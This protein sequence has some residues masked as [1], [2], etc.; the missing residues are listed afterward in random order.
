MHICY[1]ASYDSPYG[2]SARTLVFSRELV[3]LGHQVTIITSSYNH[4]MSK[5][6][7]PLNG[8]L[9]KDEIIDGVRIISVY[10]FNY[11]A[12]DQTI[13]RLIHM[14]QYSFLALIMAVVKL[15]RVDV[16]LGTT[17]PLFSGLLAWLLSKI[18]RSRFYIEIRDVWPEELIDLGSIKRG[19]LIAKIL[20]S[21]EKFL[22]K[23]SIKIISALPNTKEHVYKSGSN[24]EII[25]L[26]NPHDSDLQHQEYSGGK[27]NEL[28]IMY[29]GGSGRA[30]RINTLIEAFME[31]DLD[32][33]NLNIIGPVDFVENYFNKSNRKRPHNIKTQGFVDRS[34]LPVLFRNIDILVHPGNN[35]DQLK[36]GLNSNKILDYLASGRIVVLA[37]R[38]DNDPVSDSG[39]GFKIEPE[40]PSLMAELFRKIYYMSPETRKD[41]GKK[42]PSYLDKNFSASDLASMLSTKI[43]A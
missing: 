29:L 12:H 23:N 41:I 22:Y 9:Y 10:G 34:E 3:K 4:L 42:G 36:F 39:A 24:S 14:F 26:P 30:M 25:Y 11:K 16:I 5:D 2:G 31:L 27:Q 40:N 38:V 20:R 19:S 37:A 43:E 33:I 17:V 35:T 13:L 28:E 6:T 15:R 32:G 1:F 7:K 18:K 8:N 21:M